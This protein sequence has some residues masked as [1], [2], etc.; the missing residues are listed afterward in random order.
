MGVDVAVRIGVL[1]DRAGADAAGRDAVEPI[2]ERA[3]GRGE[4]EVVR[5]VLA[6]KA[7]LEAD[8]VAAADRA[9][10]VVDQTGGRIGSA[11]GGQRHDAGSGRAVG[12]VA[13]AGDDLERETPLSR[14]E[15][16]TFSKAVADAVVGLGVVDAFEL[17]RRS[18]N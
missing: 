14:F 4:A 12:C 13:A 8:L 18:G 11:L 7:V 9:D 3:V 15:L 16:P 5:K 1:R 2:L 17:E 10:L 6:G